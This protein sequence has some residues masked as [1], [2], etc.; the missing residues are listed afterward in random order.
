MPGR[1]VDNAKIGVKLLVVLA[2][3]AL[4]WR[5][6]GSAAIGGGAFA[7]IGVLTALN[8]GVAIFWP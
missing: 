7:A 3:V 5:G 6:R 8:I 2:V 4:A 1:A